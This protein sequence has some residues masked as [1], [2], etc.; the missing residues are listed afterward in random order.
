ML[1]GDIV[2]VPVGVSPTALAGHA[3]GLPPSNV[4]GAPPEAPVALEPP[5]ALEA[6]E[7]VEAL[8]PPCPVAEAP[9]PPGRAPHP[10]PEIASATVH[11]RRMGRALRML[12]A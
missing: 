5:V 6:P 4:V 1:P 11:Q 12:R 7:L 9:E 8:A 3:G 2:S 10:A